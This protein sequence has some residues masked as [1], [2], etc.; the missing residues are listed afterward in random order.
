MAM[1]ALE[2]QDRLGARRIK[3]NDSRRAAPFVFLL[4]IDSNKY[5]YSNEEIFNA[6]H[7]CLHAG[8]VVELCGLNATLHGVNNA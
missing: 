3:F 5:E 4:L 6:D 7:T 1:L 2:Q 8:L